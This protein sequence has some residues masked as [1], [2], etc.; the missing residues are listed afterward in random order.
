V[1]LITEKKKNGRK[2]S[3]RCSRKSYFC[4]S[5]KKGK[6]EGEKGKGTRNEKK[7]SDRNLIGG[8]RIKRR[9]AKKSGGAT[10]R[11]QPMEEAD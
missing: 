3:A 9:D 6:E 5:S 11:L 8:S 4:L 2:K 7:I 1:K 10:P